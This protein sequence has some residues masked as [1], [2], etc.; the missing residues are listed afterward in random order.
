[1][2]SLCPREKSTSSGPRQSGLRYLA[3]ELASSPLIFPRH[4]HVLFMAQSSM[5]LQLSAAASLYDP[6]QLVKYIE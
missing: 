1:M 6:R 2:I 4:Q 5:L 3:P